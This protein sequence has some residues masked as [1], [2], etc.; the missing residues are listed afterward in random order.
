MVQPYLILTSGLG[1]AGI[2]YRRSKLSLHEKRL[3]RK[4]E[5]EQRGAASVSRRKNPLRER[6]TLEEKSHKIQS[7]LTQVTSFLRKAE[8]HFARQ[9]WKETEKFLIQALA[10]DEHNIKVNRL[11]GLTFLHQGEWPRAELIYKKILELE[12]K[13]AS[14]FG[15]LGLAFYHQKKYPLAREAYLS[16]IRLDDKKANRWISLGQIY[17]KLKN[18]PAAVG[19]FQSAVRLDRNNLDYLTALAESYELAEKRPE[20]IQTY[21]KILS[22]SPYNE[23]AKDK[24]ANLKLE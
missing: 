22:L 3:Q 5:R 17:L 23:S 2:L 4:F 11:L 24:M 12:P 1:I 14:H 13:E 10:L 9:E 16:A 15:N 6:L 7:S 20:A 19:S 18:T 8:L 21:E